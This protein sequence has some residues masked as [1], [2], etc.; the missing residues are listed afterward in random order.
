MGI[1]PI[2]V[3]RFPIPIIVETVCTCTCR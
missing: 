3:A 1:K 2:A